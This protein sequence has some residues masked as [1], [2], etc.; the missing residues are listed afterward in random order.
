MKTRLITM[1]LIVCFHQL[2]AQKLSEFPSLE[3]AIK[4][5]EVEKK[6]ILVIV[7]PPAEHKH[8]IK[9]AHQENDVIKK[10]KSEFLVFETTIADKTIA[11]I[12]SLYKIRNL[13][14]FVFMHSTKEVFYSESGASTFKEKYFRM[15]DQALSKSKDSSIYDLENSY[16]SDK[17]NNQ[18]LKRYI[19]ARKAKG[20]TDNAEL[21]EEFAKNLEPADFN[22][23]QT[24]LYILKGAPY[25][26]SKAHK[27]AMNSKKIYDSI[28]NNEP[29][30]DRIAI[31]QEI[32][33]NT[34]KNAIKYKDSKQAYFAAYFARAVYGKDTRNGEWAYSNKMINY[35]KA[36]G[37]TSC[38]LKLAVPYY[39]RYYMTLNAEAT[40]KYSEKQRIESAEQ[41]F[42]KEDRNI[43]VVT[44]SQFDEIRKKHQT[45]GNI[46]KNV[47]HAELEQL[48]KQHP[49][50]V[51]QT[52]TYAVVDS[53]EYNAYANTLNSAAW[54][55]YQT[56]T[57]NVNYLT[58]AL[59]WSRRSIELSAKAAYYDTLAHLL[60]RLGYETEAIKTQK[61]AIAKA[62]I[63]KTPHEDMQKDLEK[64]KNKTL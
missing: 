53:Y 39:D 20:I 21:I 51:S 64:M 9:S 2:K 34:L 38:Y 59:L 40:K 44:K 45:Q 15:I 41:K 18:K 55:F 17:L 46:K 37:D 36:V 6:P 49:E 60:Y 35:Y 58:K 12:L 11:P 28:Y 8:N 50:A 61:D 24:I 27:L 57:T 56:G 63:Q 25:A 29:L 30:K 5:S 23:Y 54:G 22:D 62:K 47:S 33:E 31:N 32:I 3:S 16:L 4:K 1:L 14:A 42:D 19:E 48:K 43:Q 26:Y 7:Y 52:K 10:F 13:P